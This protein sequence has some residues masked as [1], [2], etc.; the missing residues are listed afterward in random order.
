MSPTP[1]SVIRGVGA[2][3]PELTVTNGDL[4]GGGLDTSDDWIRT[5]TGIATRRRVTPGTSTGDLATR[6]AREAL[7]G[8]P[9]PQLLVLATTTP[10]HPC[11]ATAPEVASRLGLGTVPAFDLAAVCSGF[12]YALAAAD[13]WIRAGMA[14]SALV[15]GAETYSTIVDPADRN[16]AILFG[17]GAGAVV[18]GLGTRDEPG[19]ILA[20]DLGSDGTGA[21]HVMIEAGGS[22]WPDPARLDGTAAHTLRMKGREVYGQAV[23][24][25]TASARRTLAQLDWPA[26]TVGAFVGH[27]ANQRILDAVADR[28]GIGAEHRHGNIRDV[29]NTA[30]ASIPLALA[31]VAR[32]R[33]VP[34]GT[35]TLLTAFGGGLTWG[36]AALTWPDPKKEPAMTTTEPTVSPVYDH[37]VH[38]LATKFEADS[39]APD[40]TFTDLGL[41]SLAVVELF[42]TLSDHWSIAL[43]DTEADPGLTVA[44]TA[45]LVEKARNERS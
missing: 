24:R 3:L 19:A 12:V 37:L 21:D 42:V 44:A 10:D 8:L 26:S 15:I 6:A 2:C 34:P 11:P 35:R 30:A 36:S 7:A 31:D 33:A 29:G 45:A 9:P 4:V 17:D 28:L 32:R 43:P 5:R 25:M 38:L 16:T 22:R 27:Q 1:A 20:T 13:A 23:R 18:L 39:P 40:A 14:T 41:D